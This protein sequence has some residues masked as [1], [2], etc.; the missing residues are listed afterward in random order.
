MEIKLAAS[1]PFDNEHDA[2]A[3][4]A[5]QAGRRGW[6][7]ARCCAEQN[8]AAFERS[9]SSA[10]SEEPEVSNANQALGQNVDEEAA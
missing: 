4:W 5:A 8:A 1:K 3:S 2:G 6:I 7:G 9:T 10:V